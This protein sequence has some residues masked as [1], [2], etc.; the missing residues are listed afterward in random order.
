[1]TTELLWNNYQQQ[2]FSF[3]QSRVKDTTSAKDI[4]QNVFTKIHEKLDAIKEEEKLQSW[5]YQIAR[6]SIV[7]FY[8]SQKN[9]SDLD[10]SISIEMETKEEVTQG[11]A[12]SIRFFIH[13]LD[14]PY[15]ESLIL[16]ELEAIPQKNIAENLGIPY[17]TV[18]SRVQRGRE[19]V[20]KMML[21]C[22]LYE[23]DRR[24]NVIDYECK[25]C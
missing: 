15:R 18:K 4:L 14:E 8:R 20:K 21:D 11:I 2:L 24:G 16:A 22:C 5:V 17:T 9:L 25:H 6:N 10:E 19:Q 23:F 7:D 1:M 13:Q 12:E 3:I